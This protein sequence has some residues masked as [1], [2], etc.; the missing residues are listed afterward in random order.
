MTQDLKYYAELNT[1][2]YIRET[3]FSDLSY[4]GVMVEVGAGPPEFI[5]MSKHFRDNGWRAISIDPNPKFVQQHK[6]A[7]NEIYQYACSADEGVSSFVINYNNDQW[8]TPEND[9]VSFSSLAIRYKNVPNHNT[10]ETIQVETIRLTTLLDKIEVK[11]VDL[12][13]I[14]TEGWELDVM[15]GFDHQRFNPKVIVLENYQYNPNY[16]L[17]MNGRGFN[18]HHN[19]EYNEIYVRS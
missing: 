14:D 6:E 16:E 4:K 19:I 7:G 3:F 5:S 18:K 2:R 9:G 12:L 10:Q 11:S 15:I 13:S 1:D 8:Y 17:F